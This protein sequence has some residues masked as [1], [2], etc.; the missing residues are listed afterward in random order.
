MNYTYHTLYGFDI[1]NLRFF[2]VYGE[3][4][5]PDLAIRK[6][7]DRILQGKSISVYGDGQTARDYTYFADIVQG[8]CSAIEYVRDHTG[9]LET[10]NLGNHN[11]VYLNQLI[12]IIGEASRVEPIIRYEEMKPGD[13][14]VT[15]ASI[16][17]ANRVL[18]YEPQ[19]SMKQGIENFIAWFRQNTVSSTAQ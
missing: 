7:V 11:P 13:V 10:F 4:Q 1:I 8:V 5:R 9:V 16:E 15:Y 18:G 17:K 6:F 2:T 14:T 12:A 3:R 19:T